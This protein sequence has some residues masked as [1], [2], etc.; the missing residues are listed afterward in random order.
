MA[1]TDYFNYQAFT[2]APRSQAL[3]RV[4]AAVMANWSESG[5]D[6]DVQQRMPALMECH[7][8]EVV[9]IRS[10]S[11]IARP[12][13]PAWDWPAAFFRTFL[14]RLEQAGEVT[15]EE[16][17]AFERDWSARTSDRT[18]FMFLPPLVDVIGVKRG[19]TA[20]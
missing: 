1:V 16:C 19:S 11:R 7:G 13:T 17:R 3:D 10:V 4:V 12:G 14:P 20:A 8:L 9:D 15:P 18:A 2:F 5:G 6:L